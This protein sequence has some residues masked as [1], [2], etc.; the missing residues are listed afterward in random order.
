MKRKIAFSI[1][2]CLLIFCMVS[3]SVQ[4]L[5]NRRA[6]AAM[7]KDSCDSAGVFLTH[8]DYVNRKLTCKIYP[9]KKGHKISFSM[10]HKEIKLARPDTVATYKPGSVYGYYQCGE[11]FRFFKNGYYTIIEKSPLVIYTIT[12]SNFSGLTDVKYFYSLKSDTDIRSLTMN[13]IEEDFK[14][15]PAFLTEVK[16]RFTI[17]TGLEATNE[18][19][20][21]LINELWGEYK[22]RNE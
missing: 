1:G 18:S 12:T 6:P 4:A 15:K 17:W 10:N 2:T 14:S 8:Q 22:Y 21:L 7:A 9:N 13:N 19:G 11:R 5:K 16:N 20:K 3:P